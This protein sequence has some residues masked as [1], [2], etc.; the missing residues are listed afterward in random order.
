MNLGE[1]QLQIDIDKTTS[2][3]CEECTSEFF[4][5]VVCIRKVSRLLSGASD[6]SLV[7]MKT[8]RCADC[9]HLNKDFNPNRK[10]GIQ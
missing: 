10:D 9:K 3:H 5:E 2:Y 8:Y 4:E 1:T 7:P 6:D